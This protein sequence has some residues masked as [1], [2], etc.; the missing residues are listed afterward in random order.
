MMALIDYCRDH[1]IEQILQLPDVQ[2][3]VQL[4]LEH[5][6]RAKE[7]ILRCATQHGNLV[8]LDLRGEET[9]WAVNRFMI[10]A[11]FPTANI[12]IH[13][14]WGLQKQ[15]TVL[16]TGKSILDR[17]SKTHVGALMLEYGGGGHAA[18]GTCQIAND[19]ADAVLQTL[20]QRINAD[21]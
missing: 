6:A 5:A 2:E 17:S 11:L 21:G 12:S 15:N 20:I 14:M 18:A 7:Q 19:Q 3:R 16:A 1:S 4:Y 8:V 13:V 10:Y 9:I